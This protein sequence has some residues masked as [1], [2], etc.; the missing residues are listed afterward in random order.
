[1]NDLKEFNISFT[2]LKM[3]NH[4]FDY[5]IDTK[6]FEHFQYDEFENADIKID[7]DF[8]KKHNMFNLMFS[9]NGFV[10]VACDLTNEPFELQVKGNLPLIVKFGEEYNDDNDEILIIPQ[11]D[12]QLNI[13][14]FIFEMIILSLPVKRVHP[15]IKDGTLKSEILNKLQEY[16]VKEET[17]DPRWAKLKELQSNKKI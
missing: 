10:T 17:I 6:F 9:S 13:S 16:K 3:G 11:N 2:G 12:F 1:M 8:E 15:G 7:L 4:Q 5:E 14:Q